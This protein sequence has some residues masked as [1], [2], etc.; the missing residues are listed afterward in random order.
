MSEANYSLRKARAG[1][2]VGIAALV[3]ALISVAYALLLR[4]RF[5]QPVEA[6]LAQQDPI[7]LFFAFVGWLV[8]A[9]TLALVTGIV[10]L[11]AGC[12]RGVAWAALAGLLHLAAWLAISPYTLI[13]LSAKWMSDSKSPV[14]AIFFLLIFWGVMAMP[15][16][17]AMIGL[18]R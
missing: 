5:D 3:L 18:R 2:G 4:L 8:I 13:D 1:R 15:W 6:E 9:L 11:I 16:L 14:L 7:S 17:G 12:L 10:G